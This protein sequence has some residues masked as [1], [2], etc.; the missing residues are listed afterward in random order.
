MKSS[1][2]VLTVPVVA[3]LLAGT[4]MLSSPAVAQTGM[5]TTRLQSEVVLDGLDNPWDMA[6]LEDGTMLFT[7]KCRGSRFG[8]PMEP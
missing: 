6:F 5:N 7:E 3:S 8:C 4:A 1:A 2:R